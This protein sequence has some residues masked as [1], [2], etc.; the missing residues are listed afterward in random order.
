MSTQP[1]SNAQV[2]ESALPVATLWDFMTCTTVKL[3]LKVK[4]VRV[5]PAHTMKAQRGGRGLAILIIK[6][7]TKW[8]GV[9]KFTL[10]PL[11]PRERTLVRPE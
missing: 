5:V 7:G 4:K 6:L 9:V 8:M 3:I 1:R 11:Y 2:N 10:R